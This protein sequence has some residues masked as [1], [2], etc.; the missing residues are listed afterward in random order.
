MIEINKLS[1]S[2][3][4]KVID[5]LTL[6]IHENGVYCIYAPS[7]RGK[8]TLF[9]A[10]AGLIKY[11]GEIKYDGR[12][13]YLFQEDRLLPWENARNNVLIVASD[14][15]KADYYI[16]KF[17]ITDFSEKPS[18]KLS[19]G[20][21]RR[22][23]IA[24]CFAYGGDIYLLDEPFKGLDRDNALLVAEEIKKL[25]PNAIVLVVTHDDDDTALLNAKR[26][27]L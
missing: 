26:I 11:S 10:I 15:D 6:S 17:G 18:A 16:E 22:V 12:I 14:S 4:K 19:G 20:M 25:A 7:G 2:F 13:A 23:A 1:V 5:G 21:K 27:D 3:D 24:R 8:T 9:N